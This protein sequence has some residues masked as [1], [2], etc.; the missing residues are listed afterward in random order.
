VTSAASADRL[1]W[2]SIGCGACRFPPILRRVIGEEFASVLARAQRGDEA[3]FAPLWLDVNP[4]L[5]R[6]LRVVSGEVDEDVAAEA[7]VTVV[8]GLARFRGDEMAWRGWVFTTARRRAVDEGRRRARRRAVLASESAGPSEPIGRT[9]PDAAQEA[10]E[11]LDTEATLALV[12]RLAPLQAEVI[13]LRVIAGLDVESVARLV[14]RR[15]GAV[16][17]AAHRGLRRLAQIMATEGVT[18]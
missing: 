16:R 4:A 12:A 11:S 1:I 2:P 15:P 17:V 6:Y 7:W 10:L 13:A 5:V 8:R 14:G 3:A 18:L 9:A